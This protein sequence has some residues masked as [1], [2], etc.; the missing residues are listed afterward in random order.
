ME[1]IEKR[2]EYF[3]ANQGY[4]YS[5]FADLI[6]VQRSSISHIITGRNKPSYDFLQKVFQAFPELNADWLIM[7]RGRIFHESDDIT[8]A[9][10][11]EMKKADERLTDTST[12]AET[13][14]ESTG[15]PTQ[16]RSGNAVVKVILFYEDGHFE[17]YRSPS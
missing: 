2:L 14:D 16:L 5:Q 12:I 7:G 11:P 6:G 4:N 15:K 17:E 10:E 1:N 9:E 13:P 8:A 3:I